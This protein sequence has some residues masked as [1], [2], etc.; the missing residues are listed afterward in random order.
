MRME[1]NTTLRAAQVSHRHIDTRDP[2]GA[3]RGACAWATGLSRLAHPPER[4]PDPPKHVRDRLRRPLSAPRRPN[5]AT[6]QRR[7]DLPKRLR[8]GSLGLSDGGRDAIGEC[9]SP[10]RVV[11]V[12]DCVGR[13]MAAMGG[14]RSVALNVIGCATL[15]CFRTT[16]PSLPRPRPSGASSRRHRRENRGEG[17]GGGHCS[18]TPALRMASIICSRRFKKTGLSLC[19]PAR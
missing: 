16:A 8:P 14:K 1:A 7:G 10:G 19:A 15:R 17:A 4:S 13:R 18:G 6:V 9:V 11:R 3:H 2:A 12:G 5:A